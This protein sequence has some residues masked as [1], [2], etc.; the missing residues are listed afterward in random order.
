MFKVT[1]DNKV[2]LERQSPES[3][4]PALGRFLDLLSADIAAGTSH[5]QPVTQAFKDRV[6]RLV[7]GVS[8]DLEQ[9][10]PAEDD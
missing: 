5:V 9:P 10:L 8:I 4:D 3:D 7:S 6:E 1:E 2:T